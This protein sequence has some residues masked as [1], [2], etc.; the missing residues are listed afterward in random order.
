MNSL[1]VQHSPRIIINILRKLI[2][3]FVEI[4]QNFIPNNRIN[5]EE[6]LLIF[7]LGF[8]GQ[9]PGLFCVVLVEFYAGTL[10]EAV[11]EVY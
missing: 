3:M 4:L 6:C 10:V 5:F 1:K 9:F 11:G 7:W 8:G 2:V